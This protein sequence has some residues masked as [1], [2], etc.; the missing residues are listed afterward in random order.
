MCHCSYLRV[1]LCVSGS[2]PGFRSSLGRTWSNS[3][4]SSVTQKTM[5]P[6]PASACHTKTHFNFRRPP[7][8]RKNRVELLASASGGRPIL[9]CRFVPAT[10]K[11]NVQRQVSAMSNRSF[12]LSKRRPASVSGC[13]LSRGRPRFNSLLPLA[14]RK[15]LVQFPAFA[16]YTKSSFTCLHVLMLIS[17]GTNPDEDASRSKRGSRPG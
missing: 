13:R 14:T 7:V 16:C 3:R 9:N 12:R 10:R 6:F 4:L 15:T 17:Q 1:S 8:T 5:V 2:I 11:T